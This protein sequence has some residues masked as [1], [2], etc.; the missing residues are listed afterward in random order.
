MSLNKKNFEELCDIALQNKILHSIF[1]KR[2]FMTE[3]MLRIEIKETIDYKVD[4]FKPNGLMKKVRGNYAELR[5]N[6]R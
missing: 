3:E 1:S 4:F 2:Y 5:N 6:N